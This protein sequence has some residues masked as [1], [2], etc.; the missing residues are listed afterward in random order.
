MYRSIVLPVVF[1]GCENC[2]LILSEER[3]LRVSE[4]RVLRRIFGRKSYEVTGE[5]CKLHNEEL[6]DLYSLPS[7][8]RVIKS[9]IMRWAGNVAR[10]GRG[11]VYTGFWWGNLRERDR[12]D[13][14]GVYGKIILRW[15]FSKLGGWA[16]TGLIWLRVRTCGGLL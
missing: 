7:I 16:W 5:W 4:N 6:N 11:E 1:C 13:Y 8:V 9:R 3:R 14:P 12:L 15:I 2:S 10:M